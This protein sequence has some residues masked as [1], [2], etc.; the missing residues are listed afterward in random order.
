M[1][2][3][4][5]ASHNKKSEGDCFVGNVGSTTH[6]YHQGRSFALLTSAALKLHIFLS[7]GAKMGSVAP[8][9]MPA[10]HVDK[11]EEELKVRSSLSSLS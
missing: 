9:G 6:Q 4:S 8:D 2:R 1:N 5:F 10:M 7:H 3:A 11:I